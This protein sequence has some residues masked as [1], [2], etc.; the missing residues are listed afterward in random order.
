MTDARGRTRF[1]QKSLPCRLVAKMF[2]VDDFQSHRTPQIDV[3]RLVGDPHR[4]A[5]QLDR[6]PVFAGHQLIMLK[7]LRRV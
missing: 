5:T 6:F 3:E 7:A 2:F 4:T 1:A